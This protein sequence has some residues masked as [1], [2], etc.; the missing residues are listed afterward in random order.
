[1]ANERCTKCGCKKEQEQ[2]E[3]SIGESWWAYVHSEEQC[4]RNQLT[5]LTA[6]RDA[7]V[8]VAQ[9]L[10]WSGPPE[11]YF[12]DGFCRGYFPSCPLCRR[13]SV[14]GHAPDCKLAAIIKQG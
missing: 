11:L 7:A 2:H 4:L 14:K 8:K 9:E 6:E 3:N 5:A 12:E 1:M 10:E 13:F